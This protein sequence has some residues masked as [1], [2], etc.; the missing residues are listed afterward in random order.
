MS[1]IFL[2]VG[3]L[4]VSRWF[5]VLVAT[6]LVVINTIANKQDSKFSLLHCMWYLA[7]GILSIF[8]AFHFAHW[9]APF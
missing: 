2:T 5:H 8:A 1:W 3:L 7:A 6:V 4:L 9:G